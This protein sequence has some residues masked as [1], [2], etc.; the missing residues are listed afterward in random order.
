MAAI[1]ISA[2][3]WAYFTASGAGSG[4]ATTGTLA[5]PTNVV[6]TY[7]TGSTVG[8]SWNAATPPGA[9]TVSYFVRRFGGP[10]A[11][12]CSTS[13]ALN[14]LHITATSCNDT[15]VPDGPHTYKV[16]AVFTTWTAQSA[17]SN[18]VTVV[19][20]NIPP[21]ITITFPSATVHKA[22][23]Y[24]SGCSPAGACG[25]AADTSPGTVASVTVTVK[26]SG[27]GNYWNGTT[28][29]VGQQL[30]TASGTT[31]WNLP[32]PASNLSSATSYTVSAF[33]TDSSGNHSTTATKAFLYD[34]VAPSVVAPSLSAAVT[35]GSNPTFVKNE[36]VTFTDAATDDASGVAS[37]SYYYCSGA[38]S[39]SSASGTLIGTSSTAAGNFSVA[40][41]TPLPADGPYSVVAVATDIA[42][43]TSNAGAHTLV[44]VDTTAPT[45]SRPIVNGNP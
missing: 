41:N 42:G 39:C 7:T 44:T 14:G 21:T 10:T 25:T 12:V 24:A 27:D 11:D 6:A 13:S 28:W 5:A 4:S 32:L 34:T 33:A 22:S 43:N 45:I 16:T 9:G 29:V 2:A 36:T 17:S 8:V 38:G 3:A 40:W 35:F 23:Q 18:S 1:A 37:V 31:S 15:N 30:L 26:R 20:D 19:S